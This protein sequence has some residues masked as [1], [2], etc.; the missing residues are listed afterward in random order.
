MKWGRG[1]GSILAAFGGG[2]GEGLIQ[3]CVLLG[4][5]PGPAWEGFSP[6]LPTPQPALWLS[7]FPSDLTVFHTLGKS[8]S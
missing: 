8:H 7:P 3:I 4:W 2:G 1:S 6:A 5:E